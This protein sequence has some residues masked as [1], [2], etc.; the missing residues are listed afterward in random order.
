M[1]FADFSTSHPIKIT[2]ISVLL[3]AIFTACLFRLEFSIDTLDQF[4]E[5]K[6]ARNDAIFIDDRLKGS[7]PLEIIIDTGKENGIHD[8]QILN[9]IESV[10]STISSIK[11][12]DLFVGK[13]FSIID[14]LKETNQALNGNDPLFYK[15]PEERAL[16]AQEL[17]LFENSGSDDLEKV[18]DSQFKKTRITLKIPYVDVVMLD[19]LITRSEQLLEEEFAGKADVKITG[20]GSLMGRTL[21]AALRSMTKSYIVIIIVIT[22]MMVLFVGSIKYGLISMFPNILPIILMMGILGA[23]GLPLD[24]NA[25]LVGSIGIGLVVD[26]TM[27]F[28]YNFR[29]F[30]EITGNV[31]TAVRETLLGTGRAMLITSLVLSTSFYVSITGKLKTTLTFGLSTGTVI[32]L[33]LLADFFLSPALMKLITKDKNK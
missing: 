1:F 15:I 19:K 11:I 10:S 13:V 22:T 28:M 3:F 20:M 24:L 4:P 23:L 29:K 6:N 5:S 33:A 30:Y 17:L 8:P 31:R 25:L 26:D 18:V 21:P 14:I 27:H 2:A 12:D 9:S 16:I 32:V 7:L